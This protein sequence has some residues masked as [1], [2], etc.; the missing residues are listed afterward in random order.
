VIGAAVGIT[1]Y[2]DRLTREAA[3]TLLK[4]MSQR[5]NLK[6]RQIAEKIVSQFETGDEASVENG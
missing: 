1:M 4:E 2:H 3:F 5:E 6:L